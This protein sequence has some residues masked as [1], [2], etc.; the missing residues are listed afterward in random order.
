MGTPPD[1]VAYQTQ[2]E[3]EQLRLAVQ[4]AVDYLR[5]LPVVPATHAKIAELE[6]ALLSPPAEA[7]LPESQPWR[8]A[9]HTVD[10]KRLALTLADG[11]IRF[12]SGVALPKDVCVEWPLSR[13]VLAPLIE[14]LVA[15]WQRLEG[16]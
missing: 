6:R 2:R 3:I 11:V 8:L 9:L 13:E 14:A 12:Q 4:A 10:G 7:P 1:L 5:L 16:G 15:E